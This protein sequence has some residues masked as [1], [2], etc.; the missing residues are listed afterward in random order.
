MKSRSLLHRVLW[1]LYAGAATASPFSRTAVLQG[2]VL[3]GTGDVLAQALERKADQSGRVD[4]HRLVRATAV[5]TLYMG[6]LL[7]FVYQ[8]AESLFP[9]P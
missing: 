9:G 4:T 1:P 7:P 5:G 2:A 8:Y 3:S 6:G